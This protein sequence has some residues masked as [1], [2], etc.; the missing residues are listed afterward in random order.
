MVKLH[1]SGKSYIAIL[2]VVMVITIIATYMLNRLISDEVEDVSADIAR[3]SFRKKY[4]NLQN[5][6]RLLQKPLFDAG[7]LVREQSDTVTVLQHL[8]ILSN[9]QLS[10]SSVVS[11]WYGMARGNGKETF[12]S[13]SRAEDMEGL[14]EYVLS[15]ARF[16]GPEVFTEVITSEKGRS[17]WRHTIHFHTS[18]GTVFYGYDLD[19][20]AVQRLFWDIDI[21]SQS[22]AYAFN[23][24]GICLLHPDTAYIGKNIFDFSP[25]RSRDTI[26]RS[27]D[28]NENMVESEFLKLEVI[29]YV[30]PLHITGDRYYVSVNFPKSINEQDINRIKKYS[31]YIYL[32]STALL[33]FVF[34]YFTRAIRIEYRRQEQLRREKAR[35]ALE[36]EVFQKESALLQLQQ[37]KNQINPHFLFNSLSALY[38]LIDQ[39]KALS[40]RFTIKLSRLYRYLIQAPSEDITEVKMEL[41]FIEEYLFLQQT[42]FGDKISFETEVKEPGSLERKIP[43]LSL[44]TLVENALKHNVATKEYPLDLRIE[45]LLDKVV[46]K[47]TYQVKEQEQAGSRFGLKYLKGIYDFYKASGFK[48]YVRDGFFYC[49]LPLL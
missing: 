45:V 3:R 21:Y 39:D 10:D 40:K 12:Y 6:F 23:S 22:Y 34:Y 8:G 31:F 1:L 7:K 38:T 37:L 25:L 48:T 5:Q 28:H 14:R 33:L 16:P 44:Q 15:R 24:G 27:S 29:N 20:Q 41:K 49:E 43:Y 2:F 4:D 32:L 30:Q 19:L 47:N 13:Q 36:K 9:I 26:F 46:V 42:R 17:L 35:L 11:N 18:Y